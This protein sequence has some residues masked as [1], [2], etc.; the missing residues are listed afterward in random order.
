[1]REVKPHPA[2]FGDLDCSVYDFLAAG[3]LLPLHT[4][5]PDDVHISIVTGGP[6]QMIG[7]RG[8][9]IL[10]PG[11]IIDWQPGENHGFGWAGAPARLVNI[12]KVH[13]GR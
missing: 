12:Q 11:E 10:V 1:M 13:H 5:G 7:D 8:D 2:R 6:L 4:H 3:D 9:R